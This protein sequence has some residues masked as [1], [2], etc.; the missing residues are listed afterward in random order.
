MEDNFKEGLKLENFK[1]QENNAKLYEV[2]DEEKE[3]I[4]A[5]FCEHQT[6]PFEAYLEFVN[7]I[8]CSLKH[9][10]IVSSAT[11]FTARIKSLESALENDT[12]KTLNDVFGMGINAGTAGE[13][14][15]LCLLLSSG[16]QKTKETVKN[17][18]N[19]YEAHHYSGYPKSAALSE[20]IKEIFS[21]DYN[22]EEM[23]EKYIK[24]LSDYEREKNAETE[25]ETKEYFIK[26]YDKLNKYLT[27]TKKIVK[28]QKLRE[29]E[30]EIKAIEN[31]YYKNQMKKPKEYLYQPIIEIQFKTV[32][33]SI[34]ATEGTA[35]HGSYKRI[36]IEQI[37]E[38]YDRNGG[39][40]FSKLP[41]KMYKSRLET[42]EF[43]NP[44]PIKKI[45]DRDEKAKEM[46]PFLIVKRKG[47]I[48]R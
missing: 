28:G 23:Y 33:V 31:A 8:L 32:A 26:Y 6:E 1:S 46:Y 2:D 15:F 41:I 5:Q 16:L 11:Y 14:E 21:T 18:D 44:L 38:E 43:G 34:E 22:G 30:K 4:Y 29:L 27:K 24:S 45:K 36:K 7:K 35:D 10:R 3:K 17:K 9:Y 39:L 48:Q 20:K 13:S 40:P 19:G 12:T 25:T 37:Q 42:D 47:E